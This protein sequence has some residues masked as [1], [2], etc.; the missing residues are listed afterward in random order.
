MGLAGSRDGIPAGYRSRSTVCVG[1][2][3]VHDV[4]LIYLPVDPKWDPD[5]LDLRFEALLVRCGF[6][7]TVRTPPA[8]K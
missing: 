4:H 5:R 3:D 6:A 1:A 8:A 2:F 7:G